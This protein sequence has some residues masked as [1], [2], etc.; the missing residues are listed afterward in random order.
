MINYV[1]DANYAPLTFAVIYRQRC[2]SPNWGVLLHSEIR[3][4]P[5]SNY[6]SPEFSQT[7]LVDSFQ[8]F[9]V[10][11]LLYL[12]TASFWAQAEKLGTE[13]SLLFLSV[14]NIDPTQY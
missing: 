7:S 12:G 6:A 1:H 11:F 9:S 4:T 5:P 14:T 10:E 8:N 13:S 3:Q 2:E